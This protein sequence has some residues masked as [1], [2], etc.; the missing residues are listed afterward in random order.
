MRAHRGQGSPTSQLRERRRLRRRRSRCSRGEVVAGDLFIDCSG[1]RGLLIEQ[2]LKTGYEDWSHWLPCD[3]AVA[4]PCASARGSSRP[5][6]APPHARPAGSGASRCSTASATATC[7]R[8][9]YISDDEAAATLMAQPRRRARWPSRARCASS[10]GRRKK[11]WNK[12]CVAMAW[13]AASSSRWSPP[14]STWCRRA[15]RTCST[16]SP[17]AASTQRGHRRIQP[18]HASSEYERVRD[19]IILHYKATER[20]DTPFWNYCREMEIPGAAA[21]AHRSL[22]GDGRVYRAGRRA[23]RQAQLDRR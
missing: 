1:F 16:Y 14:A 12:N 6:R 4:V 8:S 22:P 15:S 10:T 3:R 9:R 19:F 13:P 23:V 20:D 5:T 18:R 2:A 17:T 7:T 21:P 11:C